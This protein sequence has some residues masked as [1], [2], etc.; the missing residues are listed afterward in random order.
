MKTEPI[1]NPNEAKQSFPTFNPLTHFPPAYDIYGHQIPTNQNKNKYNILAEKDNIKIPWDRTNQLYKSTPMTRTK[2]LERRKKEKI[3]DI[4]YDLDGDGYVGGRDYVLA[5]RFDVDGDGKLNEKEKSNALEAIKN[6]VEREYVWNL[7]NQG[8]KRAFR[9]LQKR[10]KII[11]AEDFIPLQESYP[12]HPISFKE[13][14]NGIKTL[15]ELK[16]YRIKKT[17]EEINEKMANFEKSHP[18]KI[19]QE[20]YHLENKTKPLYSSV[21]EIKDK[22]HR[23]ARLKAGLSEKETD[24]KITNKDPTLAYVYSPK[25]KVKEDIRKDLLKESKDI[26]DILTS[27]KHLND[28]ERLKIRED[29]I[30]DKLFQKEEG[31]TFTKL[32]EI[33]R[34]KQNEYNLKTFADHP[35]GVHGHELPKFSANENTKEFWKL[36]DGYVEN[37]KHKSQFEYLQEI[38]YW[39]KPEELLL[40]EHR[41]YEEPK[42]IKRAFTMPSKKEELTPNINKINFYEG[43]DPNYVKPIEYKIKSDH[44]YRWSTLVSKFSSG[45]F[46]SG[47]LF[48]ALEQEDQKKEMEKLPKIK[49]L[50]EK[51][52]EKKNNNDKNKPE[53]IIPN[54]PL[55]QKFGTK[56]GLQ[57]TN[58]TNV[59]NKGF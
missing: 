27:T 2:L 4:S 52:I 21:N 40:S 18:F 12:K 19:I 20:S 43:F 14:K 8:G 33:R 24:I 15:R 6:G 32:K 55:L 5:K 45:K 53:N 26:S 56:E 23:E 47:R 46:K 49:N 41:E 22:A 34:I 54:M 35:K 44:N 29:E 17:K 50:E 16:E 10:G 28:T 11:D 36:Q 9:I 42:E 38:K 3:P 48:E 58:L 31:F 7:E 13:P 37:P 59:R 39:K 1:Q 57:L 30:F 51:S 25:H